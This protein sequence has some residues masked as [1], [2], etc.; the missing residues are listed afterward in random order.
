VNPKITQ[1]ALI[2]AVVALAWPC[3]AGG[4]SIEGLTLDTDPKEAKSVMFELVKDLAKGGCRT[5]WEGGPLKGL[6]AKRVNLLCEGRNKS[7]GQF[8]VSAI[9]ED[10]K[11]RTYSIRYPDNRMK[12]LDH[13]KEKLGEPKKVTS[14]IAR[15]CQQDGSIE[16]QASFK[17]RTTKVRFMRVSHV[18]QCG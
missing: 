10:G 5:S 12:S 6:K 3:R 17:R 11:C 18:N 13:W 2:A 14:N 16:I 8:E 7:G 9:F 4:P 15:W 1:V